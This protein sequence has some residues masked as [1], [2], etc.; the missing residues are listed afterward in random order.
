MAGPWEKYAQPAPPTGSAPWQKYA[1]PA[2]G[3]GSPGDT[4]DQAQANTDALHQL[5]AL[6]QGTAVADPQSDEWHRSTFLPAAKNMRTGEVSWA[7]PQ[8]GMDLID[9][10]MLPGDVLK[11]KVD[12]MSDEGMQR[13]INAAT[14]MTGG[15]IGRA[16]GALVDE[17]GSAVP[18]SVVRAL[19]A[20]GV[21]LDQVSQRVQALGG[22]G[23]VADL[24]NNLRDK[25]AALAATPG[26]AQTTVMDRLQA[27]RA[28]APDRLTGALDDTLGQAP[29]P[30]YLQQDIRAG[31]R[32]LGPRY[33]QVLA[34]AGPINTS[35]IA[36]NL[37]ARIPNLR[38]RAQDTLVNIRGMLNETGADTLDSSPAT[39]FQV[40]RA[41]DGILDG[42]TDGNV[43]SSLAPVR[44]Q[45]DETL[46]ASVPGI[47]AIDAQYHELGRQRA[48]VD[49]GQTVLG[50]A[51]TDPRPA[52]LADEAAAG[53]LP[54]GEIVGPSGTT[55][56]L[57]QG[58]R[59]EIDRIV[60]TNLNDRAALNSLL[61]GNS[62][63]NY[64]RLSTLFGPDR[65]DQLYRIL[66]NERAM[67]DTENKALAGSKT[68]SVTAAQQETAG[69]TKGPGIV[70]SVMDLKPGTAAASAVDRIFG[71]LGDRRATARNQAVAEA[72]MSGGNWHDPGSSGVV[73]MGILLD[74]IMRPSQQSR[75][76]QTRDQD[77]LH[78][79]T[80]GQL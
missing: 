79:I 52:E 19:R 7:V 78:A 42:E 2:F 73:P 77:I 23:A 43:I 34:Q 20:D 50:N 60:G 75:P 64:Q 63:W 13:A 21:P 59:A 8:I 36:Q 66:D 11:G 70:Q 69:P 48:A 56:R 30:S 1:A 6:T 41:I 9:T 74:A 49:R 31:Q 3:D 4:P 55:F 62:D 37:D 65:T 35:D 14:M 54:E 68:A 15:S 18:S 26:P 17:A 53:A 67:A 24:G 25:A 38:G 29:I 40:R 51:R 61:K 47:K 28:A 32:V 12:P 57:R 33:D 71:G 58:A 22:E 10:I 39:L 72:L 44:H 5:S 27:R 80:G 46:G 16:S 76:T 45:I